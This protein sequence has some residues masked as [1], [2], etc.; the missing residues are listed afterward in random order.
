VKFVFIAGQFNAMAYFP[1]S[2]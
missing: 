2:C 1:E